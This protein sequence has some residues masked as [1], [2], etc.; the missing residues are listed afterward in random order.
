RALM[1]DRPFSTRP[2]RCST[3]A[4][5]PRAM[6]DTSWPARARCAP[7]MLP[8]APAPRIAN[9]IS[10]LSFLPVSLEPRQDVVDLRNQV[11]RPRG[12][13]VRRFGNA[14]HHRVDAAQLERLV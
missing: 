7:R 4:R 6:I 10:T 9:L 3:R 1:S 2:W 5:S 12:H 8:S 14:Y 11:R 13:A